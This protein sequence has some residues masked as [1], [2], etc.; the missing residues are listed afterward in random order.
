MVARWAYVY[1]PMKENITCEFSLHIPGH[2][3]PY[4]GPLLTKFQNEKQPAKQTKT[5]LQS[6]P[7]NSNL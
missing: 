1:G 3:F 7:D 5:Q 2:F 4:Y 6:T